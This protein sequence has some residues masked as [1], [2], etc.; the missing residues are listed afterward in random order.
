MDKSIKEKRIEFLEHR[1]EKNEYLV[2]KLEA[3]ANQYYDPIDKGLIGWNLLLGSR[4]KIK[5]L[6]ISDEKEIIKLKK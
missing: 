1:I 2:H 6:I 4:D 3:T 5:K